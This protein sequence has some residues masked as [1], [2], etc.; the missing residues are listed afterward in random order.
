MRRG[1]PN[2]EENGVKK[3]G[4]VM[5]KKITRRPAWLSGFIMPVTSIPPNWD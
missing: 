2:G 3:R 1:R 5:E 4:R